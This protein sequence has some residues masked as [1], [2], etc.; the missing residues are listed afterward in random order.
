LDVVKHGSVSCPYCG[1]QYR[2][3]GPAHSGH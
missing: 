1:T 3:N 2:Y